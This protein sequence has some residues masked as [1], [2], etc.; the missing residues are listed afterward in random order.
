MG[1]QPTADMSSW[2]APTTAGMSANQRFTLAASTVPVTVK[3][4][5]RKKRMRCFFP[6]VV[7]THDAVSGVAVRV[8]CE[9]IG[10]VYPTGYVKESHKCA[11]I[12]LGV[13]RLLEC[14]LPD[15]PRQCP[16]IT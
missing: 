6:A 16:T 9:F 13:C 12:P 10:A 4:P 8:R 11:H 7:L 1:H 15:L 2:F 14:P 5:A 3:V